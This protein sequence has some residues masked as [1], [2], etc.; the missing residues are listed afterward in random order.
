MTAEPDDTPVEPTIAPAASGNTNEQQARP[1]GLVFEQQPEAQ[2]QGMG[3]LLRPLA[4]G[5]I[6]G[7]LAA[8]GLYLILAGGGPKPDQQARGLIKELQDKIKDQQDKIKEQQDKAAQ[9]SETI[10]A[11]LAEEPVK[12]ASPEELNEVRTRLD[13]MSKTAKAEEE[14]GAIAVAEASGP[15]AEACSSTG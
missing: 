2:P 11:K 1:R 8:G 9:L 3:A 13:E 4:A 7:L 5:L 10:R 6:G 12:A 15:G 14:L